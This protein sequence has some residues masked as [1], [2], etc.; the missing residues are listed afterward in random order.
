[1][2]ASVKIRTSWTDGNVI[3]EGVRIYKSTSFF[4][5]NSLPAV[6]A[7]ITD[8]SEFYEDINVIGGQTYFYMLSCFLGEQEVFTEC[9]E[10]R[11]EQASLYNGIYII[12]SE[13]DAVTL[14]LQSAIIGELDLDVY[15]KT[16][17]QI[18]SIPDDA[19]LII[20][21]HLQSG[22]TQL[23][24]LTAKFN[25]GVPVMLSTYSGSAE[26][27]ETLYPQILGIGSGFSDVGNTDVI[28]II[29]NT[30]LNAPYNTAQSNLK[31]R[32]TPYY[33][34]GLLDVAINAEVLAKKSSICVVAFLSRGAINRN[35][36]TSPANVAFASFAFTQTNQL[37][38]P[39]GRD[40]FKEL[41]KKTMR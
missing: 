11:A 32:E 29:A 3:I 4:D 7:E 41:V 38:T 6:L 23:T 9:F 26:S 17:D 37:L 39:D 28:D 18:S 22:Y 21:P 40:L 14:S 25:A 16:W 10:V 15:I 36:V 5:L 34:S 31:V 24:A 33:I 13:R 35:N 8:G 30:T 1:M 20:A 27:L 19:K 12:S 2:T